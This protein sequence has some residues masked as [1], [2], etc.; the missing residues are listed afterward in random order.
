M[1]R[2][3]GITDKTYKNFV[4][5]AGAVYLN[6]GEDGERLIGAT[7]D[8]NTFTIEQEIREIPVDGQKGPVKGLRRV[9]RVTARITANFVEFTTDV[10]KLALPGATVEGY[11]E[12]EPT[13]DAIRRALQIALGD[14][15]KNI[16]IVGN[17]SGTDQPIICGIE[18]ALADGNFEVSAADED[19]ATISIQFTAHFDPETLDKE[20]WFILNPKE[21]VE[22]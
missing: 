18:N 4:I 7:R 6:Y 11:P 21:E 8:G 13:H 12:T 19:E 17:K 16:A 20:P 3:H 15:H 9:T 14:Y 1:P 5:D 2:Y 10:L 22:A